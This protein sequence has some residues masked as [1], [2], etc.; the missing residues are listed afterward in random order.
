MPGLSLELCVS[1]SAEEHGTCRLNNFF[2]PYHPWPC[3]ITE[4]NYME[5]LVTVAFTITLLL[6]HFSVYLLKAFIIHLCSLSK[7]SGMKGQ[8]LIC[9]MVYFA[10]FLP[11]LQVQVLTE[12]SIDSCL[13]SHPPLFSCSTHLKFH[14]FK[15]WKRINLAHVLSMTSG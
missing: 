9:L 10:V 11:L 13:C 4:Q 15:F 5:V 14:T 3:W 8:W 12:I 1:C 2:W 7:A 6:W